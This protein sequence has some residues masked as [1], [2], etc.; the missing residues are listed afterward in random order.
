[1]GGVP[2]RRVLLKPLPGKATEKDLLAHHR[3]TG[4]IC[5][6][7]DGI[8]VEKP[9]GYNESYIASEINMHLRLHAKKH[10]LGYVTGEHGTMRSMPRWCGFPTALRPP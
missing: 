2:P 8:L 10:K 9:V 6:L 3:R 1:M 4:R 5:E 7:V